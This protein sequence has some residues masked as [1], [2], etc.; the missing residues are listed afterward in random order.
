LTDDNVVPIIR[1]YAVTTA[2]THDSKIDLSRVGIP[3]YRD[4]GYFGVKPEGYDATMSR[5]MR[6]FKLSIR[7]ILR[8]RGIS[9]K[10]AM[11]E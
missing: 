11:V 1:S 8:N 3:V 5:A 2:S 9:G 4:K 6:C 7:S 10:G